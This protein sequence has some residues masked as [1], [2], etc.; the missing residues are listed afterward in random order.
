MWRVT[1]QFEDPCDLVGWGAL[2][3]SVRNDCRA[4]DRGDGSFWVPM[5]ARWCREGW[6]LLGYSLPEVGVVLTDDPP[7][8][9]PTPD[10]KP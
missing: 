2:A 6:G 9:A 3:W 10:P 4:E 8:V 7:L 1:G 5:W